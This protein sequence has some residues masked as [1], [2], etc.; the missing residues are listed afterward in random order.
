MARAKSRLMIASVT[1]AL[2]SQTSCRA[3]ASASAH[4]CWAAP[5]CPRRRPGGTVTRGA[6]ARLRRPAQH[7]P[8]GRYR[9]RPTLPGAPVRTPYGIGGNGRPTSRLELWLPLRL[10]A[11]P[12]QLPSR[13][14][15]QTRVFK[16]SIPQLGAV[17]AAGDLAR[18]AVSVVAVVSVWPPGMGA[19]ALRSRVG[20]RSAA[21]GRSLRRRSV[22]DSATGVHW[23]VRASEERRALPWSWW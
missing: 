6:G 17:S 18:V 21:F 23:F 11:C 20:S 3:S 12:T 22:G 13:T 2:S 4:S 16:P 10:G 9:S 1:E 5:S 8:G 19:L 14:L 15:Q 7:K